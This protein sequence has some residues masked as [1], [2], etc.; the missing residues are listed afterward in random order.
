MV[1]E[2]ALS[3]GSVVQFAADFEQRCEPEGP[4]LFG[5]VRF[6][7]DVPYESKVLTIEPGANLISRRRADG[8]LWAM[9]VET[10]ADLAH[11]TDGARPTIDLPSDWRAVGSGQFGGDDGG[12]H[13]FGCLGATAFPRSSRRASEEG[14]QVL[15]ESKAL[16]K[17]AGAV[18]AKL[19]DADAVAA[20]APGTSLSRWAAT[21]LFDRLEGFGAVRELSGRSSFRIYGL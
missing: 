21:R 2:V 8:A 20:S 14:I 13:D 10:R 17:G 15:H 16:S 12:L 18:I 9:R 6:N 1:H 11:V 4:V 5:A 7:S 19:L 3:E